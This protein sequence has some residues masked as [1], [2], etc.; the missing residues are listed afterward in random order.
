MLD[1]CTKVYSN[2][3]IDTVCKVTMWSTTVRQNML[4]FRNQQDLPPNWQLYQNI[5]KIEK[6]LRYYSN[7]NA[8]LK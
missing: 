5:I 2:T 8:Y 7:N 4:F 6:S 1:Y 3:K